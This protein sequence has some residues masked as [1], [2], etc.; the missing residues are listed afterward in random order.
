MYRIPI[1]PDKPIIKTIDFVDYHMRAPVGDFEVEL[2]EAIDSG[3]SMGKLAFEAEKFLEKKY[4]GARKPPKKE[5]REELTDKIAELA[6]DDATM[7]TVENMK[8]MNRVVD[9]LLFSWTPATDA[10]ED[11]KQFLPEFPKDGKPSRMMYA[12]IK[13]EIYAFAMSLLQLQEDEA[14]N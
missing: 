7:S 14:K 8:I 6:S 5:Y 11:V 1:D 2:F 13:K 10:P 9:S 3:G 12:S 4:K